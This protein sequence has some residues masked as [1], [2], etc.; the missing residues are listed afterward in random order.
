MRRSR[1]T[2][3]LAAVAAA[4]LIGG[5][6]ACSGGDDGTTTLQ[7][8]SFQTGTEA[9]YLDQAVTDFN[10]A[11][12]D[13]QIEHTVVNQSDYATTALP[14]AFANGEAPDIF[15]VE[16]ATFTK[17][18]SSGVLADLTPY[19]TDDLKSDLLPTALDAVTYDDKYLALPTEMDLL[20][21]FYNKDALDAAS[22]TPPATWSEMQSAAN[23]LTTDSEYGVTMPVE[24]SAYTLFNFWPFMWMA[25][26][27]IA[28]EQG[29][30]TVDT[31]QMAQALDFWGSFFT[32]GSAPSSLQIGPWDAGNIGTG[33][34]AMQLSGTYIINAA[35]TDYAD[36]NVGVVPLPTP[37]GS[38]QLT[39][40][41]GQKLAVN[42]SSEHVDE[43]ADFI[44]GLF[45][46]TENIDFASQWVTKAKF[47]YPARQ[48]I[49]DA[50]QEVYSDGL[51]SEFTDV[52]YPTAIPEPSYPAEVTDVM[53]DALQAVMFG[54]V[55]GADAAKQAQADLESAL[56]SLEKS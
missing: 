33:V 43:A 1:K 6:T 3:I 39:V 48:S 38:G 35:E 8:W 13:V 44:F 52:I 17:F 45:G 41:G 55:S 11:H 14:T 23:T 34:S 30:F 54:G 42:A 18:A 40:G 9:E 46:D 25:G 26:A 10:E 27:D 24:D 32:D 47:S 22:V 56:G 12:T 53:G 50:N 7:F 51:R 5:V 4:A 49:I 20:G 37:D 36:V 2:R 31:P 29:N 21:L 16:P 15:Y 28:D 19:Y